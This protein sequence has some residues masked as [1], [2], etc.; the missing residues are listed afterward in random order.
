MKAP[1]RVTVLVENTASGRDTLGEHGLAFW[2]EAGSARVLFDTGQSPK[3]LFHNADRLGIDLATTDAVVLSHGHYDHTGGLGEVLDSAKG[4]RAF[5]HPGAFFRRFSRHRNGTVH[6]VGMPPGI[7]EEFLKKRTSSVTFTHGVTP[8]TGRIWVTGEVPRLNPFEDTGGEFFLD[9]ACEERDP[10]VDDQALFFDTEDGVVLI[11][12]CAHA[13][14]VNTMRYVQKFTSG[15]P[16]HAVMGGLHLINASDDRL[17][18]TVETFREFGPGLLAPA[19]C[20]GTSAQSRLWSEFPGQCKP[21]HVG[22]R[23]DFSV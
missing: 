10:I 17:D 20:T 3:V 2:I 15:R 7:D 22:S 18:Q 6:D 11:L 16:I 12:G 5:L 21:C 8:I 1:L 13:G 9:R 23:F 4:T 14:A 19:H